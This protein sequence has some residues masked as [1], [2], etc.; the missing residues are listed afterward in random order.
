ME[1]GNNEVS[2]AGEFYVLSQLTLRGFIATLTLG[3][4]KSVDILVADPKSARMFKVEVKT[5]IKKPSRDLLFSDEPLYKWT[6]SKKHEEI[7][8]KNL[9]YCFVNIKDAESMPEIFIV[10][11]KHVSE[12]VKWQHDFWMKKRNGKDSD[13]RV[14]RIK[15]DE[16]ATYL[17]NW[18]LFVQ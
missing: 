9:I 15:Q 11:C 16:I 8:D 17:N 18:K 6:M 7:N 14:F 4:T 5:T 1:L 2:L 12:Y 13:V 10:P 3:N